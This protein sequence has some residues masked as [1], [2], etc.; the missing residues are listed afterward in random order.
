MGRKLMAAKWLNQLDVHYPHL[1]DKA[2]AMNQRD[3]FHMK[4]NPEL[5][6]RRDEAKERFKKMGQER[7]GTPA[8]VDTAEESVEECRDSKRVRRVSPELAR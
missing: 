6:K 5:V 2:R 8:T 4:Y 1:A 3:K 7:R